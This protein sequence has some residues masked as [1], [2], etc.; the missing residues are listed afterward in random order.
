MS[1]DYQEKFLLEQLAEY[2][3]LL[4]EH[5]ASKNSNRNLIKTIE[6]QKAARAER[7]KDL[8]A[9]DKKDDGLV[10][11]ELGVDQL[12]IDEFQYFNESC[13]DCSYVGQSLRDR[14]YP[15]GNG[16]RGISTVNPENSGCDTSTHYRRITGTS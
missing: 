7:L 16:L 13:S 8:L 5:A 11:D 12:L 9:E 4:L 15:I 10:F 6:K 14:D 2:D 1:R 3:R